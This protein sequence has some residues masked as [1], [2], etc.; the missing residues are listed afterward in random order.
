MRMSG[1]RPDRDRQSLRGSMRQRNPMISRT[2][3]GS[4]PGR[5]VP[6]ASFARSSS[7]SAPMTGS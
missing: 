2:S 6:A 1:S 7:D 5:M 4:R 3:S